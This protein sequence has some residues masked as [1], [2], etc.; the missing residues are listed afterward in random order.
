MTK[1]PAS[2][3]RHRGQT[4]DPHAFDALRLQAVTAAQ[5]ASGELWTDYNLHDPGVSLLEALCFALTEDLFAARQP[6]PQLRGRARRRAAGA[7]RHAG[8]VQR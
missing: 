5:Q 6:V 3:A 4:A 8:V 1:P 2:I 7:R